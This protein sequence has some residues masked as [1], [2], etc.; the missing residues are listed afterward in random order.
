M[1]E[2]LIIAFCILYVGSKLLGSQ[3]SKQQNKWRNRSSSAPSSHS[4]RFA[5][6]PLPFK[7]VEPKNTDI[8]HRKSEYL[9][10]ENERRFYMALVSALPAGYCVHC[11]TALMALVQPVN[12]K[13]NSKTWAKRMDFVITDKYTKI[14]A[15]I[16][17]D[18]RTHN[19]ES[20]KKRDQYVNSVLEGR[21]KLIRFP[22]K[23]AY[24]PDEISVRLRSE[25][26]LPNEE[27]SVVI[28]T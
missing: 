24:C 19:W 10:T 8:P 2:L 20:R 6:E 3:S 5:D 26:N 14:L 22:S 9:T 28:P 23:R 13:D 25:L 17:L 15:V 7:P 12:R 16:E 18:D 11:Q 27:P 1:I 21:H 4:I